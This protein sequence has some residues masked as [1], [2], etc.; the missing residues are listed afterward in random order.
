MNEARHAPGD[1]EL[2]DRF[3]ERLERGDV[4]A[5]LSDCCETHPH[6]AAELGALAESHRLLAR[7]RPED[8]LP[9]VRLG[10]FR[11]V[12]LVGRGGMGDVYEAV[13]EP[14]GRRVAVKAIRP[15]RVSAVA[16]ERFLR[17]QQVLADLHHTHVVPIFAAGCDGDTHY[18]AM[19]YVQG[20]TLREILRQERPV[21]GGP[22]GS[23]AYFRAA[24][25]MVADAAEAVDYAHGRGV[26]HRDL[27]PGNLMVD[28]AGHVWVLDFGLA[29]YLDGQSRPDAWQESGEQTATGAAG[30]P[31]YL[32]PEQLDG[33]ADV[34]TDVW[35]LGAVL[36]E[37][38]SLRR[39][40]ATERRVSA[41]VSELALAAVADGG[42]AATSDPIAHRRLELARPLPSPQ[43]SGL[44]SDLGAICEKCLALEP[45]S[46]YASAQALAEDLRCFLRGAETTARPWGPA[47]RAWRWCRRHPARVRSSAIAAL[48]LLAAAL[49]GHVLQLRAGNA[50]QAE[51]LAALAETQLDLVKR[52]V[53]VT[54]RQDKLRGLLARRD[55]GPE[56]VEALRGYLREAQADFERWFARPG[57]L[58]NLLLFDLEGDLVADSLVNAPSE[59]RNYAER[60]Y[61]V[62]LMREADL[63]AVHASRVYPSFP[64][65]E[66]KFAVI[67][68]VHDGRRCLGLLAATV[69]LAPRLV[70]LDMKDEPPSAG[71]ACPMDWTYPERHGVPAERRHGH[72]FVLHAGYRDRGRTPIRVSGRALDEL[73]QDG[74]RARDAEYFTAEACFADYVRIGDSPFVAVVK[75]PYSWSILSLF[76][77]G[78]AL[79]VAAAWRLA[80]RVRRLLLSRSAPRAASR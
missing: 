29:G 16:R 10:D 77:L 18:F 51:K 53:A 32:A 52:A 22:H 67:T 55:R 38:L 54:A 80:G 40:F 34:R 49:L 15:A 63:N 46:R 48:L 75:Q 31:E 78:G 27:K 20:R 35:G 66:L 8:G 45:A 30:T 26:L 68:R 71:V 19:P 74:R 25:A 47:E 59:G 3:V 61:Y 69:P 64:G 6:L 36:Y 56:G 1:E 9:P 37:V 43:A 33:A 57:P 17:E 39:A 72:V 12:R 44:P 14:F 7:V 50:Q 24:A 73:K 28:D 42:R 65:N 23:P 58:V 76:A 21:L 70:V 4:D 79:A 2:L 5:A 11:I 41:S 60:D 13:Q 62:G